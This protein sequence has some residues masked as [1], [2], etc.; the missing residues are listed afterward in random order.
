MVTGP[1]RNSEK[2]FGNSTRILNP[3]IIY[4]KRGMNKEEIMVKIKLIG[5]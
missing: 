5:D 1:V 2:S 4:S 3:T